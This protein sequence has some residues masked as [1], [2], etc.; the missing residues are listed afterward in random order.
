[1]WGWKQKLVVERHN[2]LWHVIDET[3]G[4]VIESFS[5]KRDAVAAVAAVAMIER[6]NNQEALAAK[7][8]PGNPA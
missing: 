3:S 4:G 2:G 7:L 8:C 6:M 5:T 1:M